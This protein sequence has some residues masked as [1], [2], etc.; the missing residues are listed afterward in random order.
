MFQ[1]IWIVIV[2]LVLG[3]LAKLILPGKQAI[4]LWLT[5]LLGIAGALLGNAIAGW[6]GVRHTSG[7]DWI[8]H[9]LQV[10]VAVFLVAV[11]APVWGSN[12]SGAGTGTSGRRGR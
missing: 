1:I 9:I 12:R 7:V 4:P 8:R 3:L 11:V 5:T 6:I 2:G 10:G